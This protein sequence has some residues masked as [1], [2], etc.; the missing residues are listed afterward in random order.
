MSLEGVF[1][2]VI[3]FHCLVVDTKFHFLQR[4]SRE[5][6]IKAQVYVE[7]SFSTSR[8]TFVSIW[9]RSL[10]FKLSWSI[11]LCVIALP[12]ATCRFTMIHLWSDK[13]SR[14][15]SHRHGTNSKI[16]IVLEH[17]LLWRR[18]GEGLTS[19]AEKKARKAN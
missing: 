7:L 4:P 19:P 6:R 10:P 12:S 13:H 5:P 8:G 2:F 3:S 9:V 16:V 1:I 17:H 14:T 15:K 11:C 18:Q